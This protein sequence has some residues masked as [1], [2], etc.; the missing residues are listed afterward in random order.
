[1]NASDISNQLTEGTILE[2][3]HWTEPVRVLT[4]KV[5]CHRVEV[6]AVGVNTKRLWTKLLNADE[7]DGVIKLTL[8]GE[9]AA[10]D[11]NPSHAGCIDAKRST[12]LDDTLLPGRGSLGPVV[13]LIG[14]A[15][16]PLRGGEHL[17]IPPEHEKLA[18]KAQDTGRW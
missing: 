11:G 3:P 6:Q 15:Y 13:G 18:G 14:P 17:S 9:L 7:F 2:G 4:A 10:L 1:M 16:N 5:R 12:D 8:A